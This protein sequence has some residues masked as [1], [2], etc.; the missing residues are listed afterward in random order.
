[1]SIRYIATA[2]DFEKVPGKPIVYWLSA[3]MINT[4]ENKCIS[5]LCEIKQGLATCNNGLFVRYWNE[6][7]FRK[8]GFG[9]SSN[10]E[11]ENSEKKWYPYNKGGGY[12]K[13]YGNN[14]F[15]VNWYHQGKD[16]HEY[17]HIPLDFSAAPVRAKQYYFRSGITYNLIASTGFSAR[18]I[19]GGYIFDV[20]G[21]MLFPSEKIKQ[22]ILGLLETKLTS[23]YL[24]AINSTLNFQVGD[25]GKVP[26]IISDIYFDKVEELVQECI[27]LSK[28][29]WDSFEISWGF[30]SHVLTRGKNKGKLLSD[31][32]ID[33]ERECNERFTCL[34]ANEEEL[35]RLFIQIY[36]LEDEL[37]PEV[38]EKDVT[39]RLADKERDIRSLISYLV[40]IV[41]GRY[42][43]DVD[44]LAYAG[45]EWDVSKYITYQP[46]DDGIVPIYTKLGM[47]DGLTTKIIKLIKI[48]YG[49]DTYRQ[50]IDFIAEA[51]GKNNN[52][53]SEETLNR[54]LNDGF[55]QDHLKIYQK[56]PIY[57]MFSSGKK[58]GFKCLIYMHR[59]NED[60]LAR[61]NAKYYL[62]ESTRK[63]NELDELNGRI[64]KAEGKEKTRLEKER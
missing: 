41:M 13:W 15:V 35:N 33:W 62:P 20:G 7:D 59:Y 21:S 18:S 17:N 12:R 37:T 60:T 63:K 51:L 36:G 4:F 6:V 56:R 1:M 54:Y 46:D 32:F 49:E 47:E 24:A 3:D 22:Y 19:D 53:S 30:G 5:D 25:I 64:T 38:E 50:N 57:W 52:E 2:E 48:I 43:L 42:S 58:A 61:I 11:T 40:G 44:G 27:N 45:G 28:K 10:K 55:Y 14:Y 9:F 31:K 26:V 39:I 8:I 34:K 23:V 16:I 29:D